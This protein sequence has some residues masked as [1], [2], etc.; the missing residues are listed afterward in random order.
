MDKLELALDQ[1][2]YHDG[3]T[4]LDYCL[5]GAIESRWICAIISGEKG[6]YKSNTLLADGYGVFHGYDVFDDQTNK[7]YITNWDDMP[8]WEL[9][10]HHL[11]YRPLDFANLIGEALKEHKPKSWIGWD[12][13]RIH[14][15]TSLYSTDRE[16]WEVLSA[17]WA[18]F[19]GLLAIFECSAPTKMD[20]ISFI[21]GDMNF[22][23]ELTGRKM[24]EVYRWF[25]KGNLYDKMQVDEFRIDIERSPVHPER[26][27]SEIWNRYNDKTLAIREESAS[28]MQTTLVEMDKP[29]QVITKQPKE[30]QYCH[31]LMNE[32][33]LKTH[34]P[35]C[36]LRP[37]TPLPLVHN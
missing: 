2:I 18:G 23:I 6:V 11:V 22:D 32:W 24:K 9:V 35:V 30:C 36:K 28:T 20:V 7:G 19:R 25:S 10:L 16:K 31:K 29:V 15:S 37:L 12:D 33:N 4:F 1:G 34:E 27:P 21:R 3:W 26:V 14:L 8:A 5:T 17:N 13:I